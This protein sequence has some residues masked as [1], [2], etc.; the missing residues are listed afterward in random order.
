MV[1]CLVIVFFFFWFGY[2]CRGYNATSA[3][4]QK[5][6]YIIYSSWEEAEMA[7]FS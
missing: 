3:L 4:I 1:I 2:H 6:L 5:A 7:L